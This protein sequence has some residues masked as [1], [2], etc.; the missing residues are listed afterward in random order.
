[1]IAST[2]DRPPFLQ[3]LACSWSVNDL[4]LPVPQRVMTGPVLDAAVQLQF[5]L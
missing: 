3:Q 1:V 4:Q 5:A 2:P